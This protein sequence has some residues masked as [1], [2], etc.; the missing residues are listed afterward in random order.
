MTKRV[1]IAD[2]TEDIRVLLRIVLGHGDFE[3]VAV[4]TDGTEAMSMW[5][6]VRES[7]LFALILDQRMPGMT[8]LE[9]ARRVLA[10][11]PDQRVILFSAHLDSALREEAIAIGVSAVID[12]EELIGLASHPALAA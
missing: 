12:K 1:L 6:A 4:A 7:G 3:I 2:D 10:H 9:V 8:G 5:E 11:S